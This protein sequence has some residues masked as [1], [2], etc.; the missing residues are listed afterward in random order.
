[1]NLSDRVR[2]SSRHW[3]CAN[4]SGTVIGFEPKKLCPYLVALDEN[5]VGQYNLLYFQ[6]SDLR[7]IN[8][9]GTDKP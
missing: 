9:D 3:L 5:Y 1:M 8:P 4:M 7:K 6:L 2:V